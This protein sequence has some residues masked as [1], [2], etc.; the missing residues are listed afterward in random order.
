[1]EHATIFGGFGGQGLLFAGHVL[2]QA[3][4]HRRPDGVVDAVL[5]ARDARRHGVVHGHH[6][7]PPDRL[8]DRRPR[9]LRGRPQPAVA[10]EVRTAARRRAGSSSSTTRSSRPNRD[11]PMSRWWPSRVPRWPG[12]PAT[13]GSSVWSHSV[14]WSPDRRSSAV[15]RS[16]RRS[17]TSSGR[18][19]G[20][21]RGEHGGIRQRLRRGGPVNTRSPYAG[22]RIAGR[23][24][25]VARGGPDVRFASGSP[26][27]PAG[28]AA[29]SEGPC[30]STS[31]P[32]TAAR[33]ARWRPG[34]R[35]QAAARRWLPTRSRPSSPPNR[36]TVTGRSLVRAMRRNTA[37]RSGN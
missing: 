30:G 34:R 15:S 7:G 8:A 17:S 9:R 20:V 26:R 32:A 2:A 19:T 21:D 36:R 33:S 23:R 12:R 24:R 13:S 29:R 3:A 35:G 27:G 37:A 18:P 6:R 22:A 25:E 1:M 11:G 16:G 28:L 4:V 31:G 10:R 14:A 5:R